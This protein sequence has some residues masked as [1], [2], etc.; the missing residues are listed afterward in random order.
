MKRCL[1][2]ILLCGLSLPTFAKNFWDDHAEGWHWYQD[3]K[4]QKSAQR[5]KPI[6]PIQEMNAVQLAVKQ[7]LNK[8]ILNPTP[9]NVKNYISLQNKVAAQ[10][11]HFSDTWRRVI[12][13]T[14]SLDYSQN[15]PTNQVGKQTY[16]DNH[17]AAQ[18]AAILRLAKTHGLFFFFKGNCPYCHRFSPIVKAFT[19]RYGMAVIPISLDGGSL[20]EFPNAKANNGA[21]N[22]LNVGVVPA[23]FAVNPKNNDVIPLANGLI[24]EQELAQR[25]TVLTTRRPDY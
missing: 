18:D 20:P 22:R 4:E 2:I 24:S 6:D 21:A 25:I 8:A 13:Q 9:G 14:P 10:A 7:A 17:R 1:L 3:P 12:W 16:L 5:S 15:Y 19:E 11:S 23:L